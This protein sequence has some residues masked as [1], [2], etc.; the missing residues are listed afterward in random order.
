MLDRRWGRMGSENMEAAGREAVPQVCREMGETDGR[1]TCIH[2]R[3]LFFSFV[4]LWARF[5]HVCV[6]REMTQEDKS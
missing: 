1:H 4:K 6:L 3:L 5:Q 2:K